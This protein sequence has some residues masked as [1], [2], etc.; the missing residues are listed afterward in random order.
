MQITKTGHKIQ[1]HLTGASAIK[2]KLVLPDGNVI[3]DH[4]CDKRHYFTHTGALDREFT[5]YSL[6]IDARNKG[7]KLKSYDVVNGDIVG[8]VEWL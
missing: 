4:V 1:L 8:K 7:V 3:M 2:I 5:D 6:G